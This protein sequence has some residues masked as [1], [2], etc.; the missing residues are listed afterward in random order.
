MVPPAFSLIKNPS[1]YLDRMVF[2]SISIHTSQFSYHTEITLQDVP[3][4]EYTLRL[5]V[6]NVETE[7]QKNDNHTWTPAQ[8]QYVPY[9]PNTYTHWWVCIHRGVPP[10]SQILAEVR[11]KSGHSIWAKYR[12]AR[13]FIDLHGLFSDYWNS[14]NHEFTVFGQSLSPTGPHRSD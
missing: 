9:F 7:L 10:T 14:T 6:G 8:R 13:E 1:L 12:E 4:R 5:F 3:R 2:T 11:M